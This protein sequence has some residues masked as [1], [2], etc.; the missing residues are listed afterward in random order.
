[1]MCQTNKENIKI[2]HIQ[3]NI[4]INST[5]FHSVFFYTRLKT[6]II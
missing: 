5:T 1:M 6:L 3:Q 4:K 2:Q